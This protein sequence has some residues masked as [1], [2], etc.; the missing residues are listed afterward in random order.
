MFINNSTFLHGKCKEW[1]TQIDGFGEP[2]EE[3]WEMRK[4]AICRCWALI[5]LPYFSTQCLVVTSA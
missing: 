5:S 2:A 1:E 3:I 4:R